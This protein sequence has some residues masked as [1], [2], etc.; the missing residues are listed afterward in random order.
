[1]GVVALVQ[2]AAGLVQPWAAPVPTPA[3]EPSAGLG[4][5]RLGAQGLVGQ[6]VEG[7][8]P[9]QEPLERRRPSPQRIPGL[10]CVR[11]KCLR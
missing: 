4:L 9:G 10:R 1:M 8:G 6:G 11:C 2:G 5:G 3:C 7:Q